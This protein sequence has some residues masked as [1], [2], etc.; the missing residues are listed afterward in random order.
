MHARRDQVVARTFRCGASQNGCLDLEESELTEHGPG[1]LQEAVTQEKMLLQV[2]PSEIQVTVEEPQFLGGQRLSLGPEYTDR[3]LLGRWPGQD[4]QVARP[5]LDVA[6]GHPGIA[7]VG[8]THADRAGHQHHGLGPDSGGQLQYGSGRPVRAE[9]DL[10][11][12]V[13][14][15]Q[16]EEDESAQ[17][18]A[19]MNPPSQADGLAI[20]FKS[21]SAA[22]MRAH[23]GGCHRLGSGNIVLNIQVPE[24]A[25]KRRLDTSAGWSQPSAVQTLPALAVMAEATTT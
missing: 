10:D 21:E 2:E 3:Q 17:V 12:S 14:I 1:T 16:V 22:P 9:R 20:V 25:S 18:A 8:R 24:W 4:P 19:A 11:Q 5:D 13:P 7:L 23:R 15:S 6:G